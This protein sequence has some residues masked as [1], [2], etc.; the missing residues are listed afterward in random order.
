MG[1][2]WNENL[3][4][5]PL[6]SGLRGIGGIFPFWEAENIKCTGH[7]IIAIQKK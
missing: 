2:K 1:A 3:L 7:V 4:T 5:L 6:F